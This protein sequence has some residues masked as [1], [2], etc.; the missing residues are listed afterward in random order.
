MLAYSIASMLRFLTPTSDQCEN[1]LFK[2]YL[3]RTLHQPQH[4][5]TFTYGNNLQV[6][7][8][9]KHYQ[10]RNDCHPDIPSKLYKL[11]KHQDHM[12][13]IRLLDNLVGLGSNSIWQ[14][15]TRKVSDW[16]YTI[17]EEEAN[18]M[19]HFQILRKVIDQGKWLREKEIKGIVEAVVNETPVIDL[20][21]H[22]FPTEHGQLMLCGIDELLTYHYLVAEYFIT[23]SMDVLP[24]GKIF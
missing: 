3:L 22:L 14:L 10:F 2:G 12:G 6:D 8:T 13:L 19:D 23:A 15:W 5:K 17:L 24:E 20:H 11:S 21:T 1:G 18:G 9:N 16:Y 7:F 4:Q